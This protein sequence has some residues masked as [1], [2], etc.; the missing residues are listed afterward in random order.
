MTRKKFINA[1]G[2]EILIWYL[3]ARFVTHSDH[4]CGN[5]EE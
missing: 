4:A 2:F 1:V 5:V 3:F